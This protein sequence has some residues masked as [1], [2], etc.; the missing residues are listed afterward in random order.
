MD[1]EIRD[2]NRKDYGRAIDFAIKGMNFNRYVDGKTELRLYGRYFLYLELK[3]ATQVFAAY[4]DDRLVGVLLADMKDEPKRY[5]SFWG[6]LYV[7]IVKTV[8]AIAYK[9]GNARYD[10]ANAAMFKEYK[11]R[12]VPDGE[13]CFLAAD[14]AIQ[15]KCIGTQLLNELAKREKGKLIYLYTDDNC[16]YQ[17][18][19]HKGFERSE[20]KEIEIEIHGRIVPLTC[21]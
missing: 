14:P 10:T 19:E 18:Y 13:I 7:K 6:N 20:K 5:T 15:G 16:T 11:K 1:I 8:M 4:M 2:L 17:F 21:L 9:N 3:H 12:V